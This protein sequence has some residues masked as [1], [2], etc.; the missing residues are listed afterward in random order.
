MFLGFSARLVGRSAMPDRFDSSEIISIPPLP[1]SVLRLAEMVTQSKTDIEEIAHV[2]GYDP[3]LTASA[4]RWANSSW[5]QSETAIQDVWGAVV[6]LGSENILKLAVGYHMMASIRKICGGLDATE[7]VLWQHSVATAV[8]VEMLKNSA[9]QAI[10]PIAF[11]AAI[12]HDIGK[13]IMGR[14][15]G[16][17]KT[18]A[19][20]RRFM[21]EKRTDSLTAER[22][23]TGADHVAL[24]L[25]IVE[26]WNI[27]PQIVNVIARHHNP[28]EAPDLLVD[29]VAFADAV[30]RR[31]GWGADALAPDVEV[32]VPAGVK[33]RLGLDDQ[34]I[35]EVEEKTREEF[36]KTA[37]QWGA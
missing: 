24:G 28:E 4:I 29:A 17:Q 37:S 23:V 33:Q 13:I 19:Q 30:S 32:E 35:R 7:N 11:T 20:V 34:R 2:I 15:N 14:N 21:D 31:I 36:A 18:M 25:R 26:R 22:E 3:I 12:M 6:R 8:A 27:P 1:V 5:S 9:G 16:Y 10:P